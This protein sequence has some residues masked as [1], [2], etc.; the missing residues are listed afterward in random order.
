MSTHFRPSRPETAVPPHK[1]APFKPSSV[2]QLRNSG[3]AASA[4][5]WLPF[6]AGLYV[7]V[8]SLGESGITVRL[9]AQT[10]PVLRS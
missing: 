8:H 6:R 1:A 5:V 3:R 7:G 4:T 9:F 2:H 10:L